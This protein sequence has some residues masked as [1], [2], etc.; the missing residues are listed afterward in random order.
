M[1]I[2]LTLAAA[3]SA[4]QL[5][6]ALPYQPSEAEERGSAAGLW[7]TTFGQNQRLS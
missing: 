4:V 5:V 7:S 1:D 3:A 2:I 6:Y